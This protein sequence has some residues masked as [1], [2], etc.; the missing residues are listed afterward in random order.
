[1]ITLILITDE[2]NAHHCYFPIKPQANYTGE[3]YAFTFYNKTTMVWVQ[4]FTANNIFLPVS[5]LN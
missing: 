4:K 5:Y 1:M 2:D 3:C